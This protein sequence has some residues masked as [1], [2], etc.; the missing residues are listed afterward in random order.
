MGNYFLVISIASQA[1]FSGGKNLAAV[2][3]ET[4]SRKLLNER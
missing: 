2:H 4:L 3:S 1:A